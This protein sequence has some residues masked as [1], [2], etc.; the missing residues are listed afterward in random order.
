MKK[1]TK[2]IIIVSA[3]LLILCIIFWRYVFLMIYT[4][5]FY[6]LWGALYISTLFQ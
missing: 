4:I 5:V 6:L 3:V 1:K 2:I